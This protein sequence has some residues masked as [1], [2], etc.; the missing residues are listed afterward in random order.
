MPVEIYRAEDPA[1]VTVDCRDVVTAE[2]M[3]YILDRCLAAVKTRPQHFLIDCSNL[4]TLAPGALN[5]LASYSDFLQHPNT[6]W[7]AFVTDN[8][9]LKTSIQLLFDRSALR[10]F[11]DRETASSFLDEISVT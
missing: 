10:I 11:N 2:D 6:R 7:L 1:T 9:L 4:I 5:A 3:R 8:S